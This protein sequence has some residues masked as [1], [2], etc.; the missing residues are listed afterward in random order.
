MHSSYSSPPPPRLTPS[1]TLCSS[2]SA[3]RPISA[4]SSSLLLL[5]P[6]TP[7]SMPLASSTQATRFRLASARSSVR[8]LWSNPPP[9]AAAG[10]AGTVPVSKLDRRARRMF[11]GLIVVFESTG[12]GQQ[13]ESRTRQKGGVLSLPYTSG[14]CGC[15]LPTK[16]RTRAISAM[17]PASRAP[18]GPVG[19]NAPHTQHEAMRGNIF[20]AFKPTSCGTGRETERFMPTISQ[21]PVTGG[22]CEEKKKI[23]SLPAR[24]DEGA[25]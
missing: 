20:S 9:A 22:W 3:L 12:K 11:A 2:P 5:A 25:P 13:V 17:V 24:D 21:Q 6:S 4:A 18:W 16:A 14:C 1:L 10:V 8:R 19:V 15:L 23:P 7:S